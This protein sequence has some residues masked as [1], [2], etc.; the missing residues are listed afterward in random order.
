MM[1]DESLKNEYFFKLIE[2]VRFAKMQRDKL[3]D[4]TV[5]NRHII[6][7]LPEMNELLDKLYSMGMNDSELDP[8][9]LKYREFVNSAG[10]EEHKAQMQALRKY[11][12]FDA[13]CKKFEE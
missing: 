4:T 10:N 13:L 7:V 11:A 12:G 9:A 8:A 2:A 6:K 5:Y 1:T 3:G